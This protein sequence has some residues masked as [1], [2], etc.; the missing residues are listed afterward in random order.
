MS[1]RQKVRKSD[2]PHKTWRFVDVRERCE[3]SRLMDWEVED[4]VSYSARPEVTPYRLRR[5]AAYRKQRGVLTEA[6]AAG[7]GVRA[8]RAGV[9]AFSLARRSLSVLDGM[10]CW[11]IASVDGGLSSHG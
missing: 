4:G 5:K 2:K 10:G 7:S 3:R 1:N 9:T 11:S 6:V 8:E